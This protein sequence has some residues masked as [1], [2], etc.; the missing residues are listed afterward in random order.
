MENAN[1][2]L[3]LS[4]LLTLVAGFCDTVT[5]I[6]AGQLFSAH[7]TGNFIVFAA[8]VVQHAGTADWTKLLSFPVFVAAVAVGQW[9]SQAAANRYALLVTEGGVLV[10]SG[11]LALARFG[12]AHAWLAEVAAMMVVFAMGLQNAFGRLFSKETYG[13]TTVMTG[14]VAQATLDVT[15]T[16]AA[17]GP[18]ALPAGTIPKSLWLIAGFLA[19]CLTGG[20]AAKFFGLWPVA[21]PGVLLLGFAASYRATKPEGRAAAAKGS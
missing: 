14:T 9:L 2:V 11:L 1:K 20:L 15:T 7:V 4:L 17:S 12:P 5:F 6:A 21:L 18:D 10:L 19:G 8:N 3:H 13:P 16:L